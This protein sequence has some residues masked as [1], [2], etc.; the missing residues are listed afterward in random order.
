MAVP[1][2]SLT[3]RILLLAVCILLAQ[4]AIGRTIYVDDDASPGGDGQTW[5][6]SYNYLQDALTAAVSGDEIWVAAGTYYPSVVVGGTGDRYKTFQ[7]I[8]GVA[9]Y[10]GFP[11]TGDPMWENRD[12]NVHEAIFNH[13]VCEGMKRDAVWKTRGP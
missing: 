5:A 10:G 7:M 9:I 13:T 6:S 11:D 3:G 4:P 2:R 12:P 1:S 8:N